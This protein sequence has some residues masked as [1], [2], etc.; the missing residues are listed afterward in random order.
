MPLKRMEKLWNVPNIMQIF[1]VYKT[2]SPGIGAIV[3]G[4]CVMSWL[5]SAH[6]A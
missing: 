1:M 2:R 4:C 5:I 3:S 6:T